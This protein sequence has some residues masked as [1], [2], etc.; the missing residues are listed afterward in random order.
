VLWCHAKHVD[1]LVTLLE[2]GMN[3]FWHE[4]D[5][6]VVTSFGF[7]WAFPGQP[8]GYGRTVAVMPEA[9]HEEYDLSKF[10]AVCS[11]FAR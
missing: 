9:H 6:Y 10:Y 4:Q 3:C 8:A 11:D 1:A 7:I 2:L 5:D